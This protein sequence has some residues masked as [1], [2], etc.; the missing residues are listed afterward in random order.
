MGE[1]INDSAA[2][3]SCAGCFFADASPHRNI[4]CR[5]RAPRAILLLE[6]PRIWPYVAPND[7]CGE[8]ASRQ[9]KV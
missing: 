6:Q 1:T 3:R 9:E 5:R 8:Y 7:W 2:Q 4:E